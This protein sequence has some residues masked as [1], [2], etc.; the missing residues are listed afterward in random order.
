MLLTQPRIE[1]NETPSSSKYDPTGWSEVKAS[2][3]R[4]AHCP[5]PEL[6]RR[7]PISTGQKICYRWVKLK[8]EG[9]AVR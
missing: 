2:R 3:A 5:T 1:P 8:P 6:P 7:F 9:V 4:A